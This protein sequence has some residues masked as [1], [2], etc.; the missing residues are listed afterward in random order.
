M[1]KPPTVA[2]GTARGLHLDNRATRETAQL[3]LI[4]DELLWALSM[5]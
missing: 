2:P 4:G 3:F 5:Q 1:M